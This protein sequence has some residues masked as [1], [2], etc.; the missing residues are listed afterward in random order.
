[1]RHNENAITLIE[2]LATIVLTFVI[3]TL[4]FSVTTSAINH[5]KETETTSQVQSEINRFLLQLTDTHKDSREYTIFRGSAS[6]YDLIIDDESHYTF[7]GI[8]ENYDLYIGE[9][10]RTADQELISDTKVEIGERALISNKKKYDVHI[11]V[12]DSEH[13]FG[14]IELSTTISR[15]TSESSD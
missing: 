15:L 3:G 14:Q 13:R 12:T 1:M 5:Y 7:N 11:V 9:T 4:V 2:V 8:A 10:I 6:S